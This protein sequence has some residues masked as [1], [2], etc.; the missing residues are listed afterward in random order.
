MAEEVP[1][2]RLH[3]TVQFDPSNQGKLFNVRTSNSLEFQEEECK[4]EKAFHS[5]ENGKS[6]VRWKRS[7]NGETKSNAELIEWS[8]GRTEI[9]VG[10]E[11]FE[12]TR[13]N[14]SK[15]TALFGPAGFACQRLV[16][17]IAEQMIIRKRFIVN[18]RSL[19]FSSISHHSAKDSKFKA[20][21]SK[22][23]SRPK[24]E[25]IVLQK[26]D[27]QDIQKL[28]RIENSKMLARK[29]EEHLRR[30]KLE[31]TEIFQRKNIELS[32]R[33]LE[34]DSSEDHSDRKSVV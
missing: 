31:R 14:V 4:D 12:I 34:G 8:D 16:S 20:T 10:S 19:Q 17:P 28:R 2:Y 7:E 22:S 24:V 3:P 30:M 11:T 5:K 25:P 15:S 21:L 23:A 29:R 18:F 27:T 32:R 26:T 6:A 9:R 33:F 13:Q 1:I